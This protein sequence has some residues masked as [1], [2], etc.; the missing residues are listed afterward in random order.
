MDPELFDHVQEMRRDRNED[1]RGFSGMSPW[2]S[3]MIC[4]KCGNYFRVKHRH[5]KMCWE[6][7]DS[8]RKAEPCKNTFVYETAREWH[9][10]EVMRRV[11]RDRL[12]VVKRMTEII[13]RVVKDTERR[14]H[15]HM[16]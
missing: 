8:Y 13:D 9:V 12:D 7:R 3:K 4:G 6:C 2:S 10:K 1:V 16:R 5:W 15:L 14:R 11:L